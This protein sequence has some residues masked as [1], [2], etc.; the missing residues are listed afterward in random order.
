MVNTR[1]IREEALAEAAASPFVGSDKQGLAACD[2][3]QRRPVAMTVN[4]DNAVST[5]CALERSKGGE[6]GSKSIL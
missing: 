6:H 2:H 4:E 5:S 1:I 3:Q